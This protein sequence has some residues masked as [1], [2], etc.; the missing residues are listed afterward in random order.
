MAKI[1]ETQHIWKDDAFI[2]WKDANVH[3]LA[4]S[5]QF[6]SAVFEG[7]RCYATPKGPAIFRLR[8]HLK[9]ML[10]SCKIYRMPVP[11]TIDE[12]VEAN[13]ALVRLRRDTNRGT[14]VQLRRRASDGHRGHVGRR[15]RDLRRAA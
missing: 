12:L 2:D 13:R 6:G 9:R 4:H 8:E 15:Q 1:G 14:H 10:N 5:V 3:V 7:I 11:Y